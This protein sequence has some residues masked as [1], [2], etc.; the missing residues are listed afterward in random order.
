[1]EIVQSMQSPGV[2][3]TQQTCMSTLPY[4][5]VGWRHRTRGLAWFGRGDRNVASI[6]G[7]AAIL[8][9][10]RLVSMP[11]V[12]RSH[13]QVESLQL[14][15]EPS[16]LGFGATLTLPLHNTASNG[17]VG[18]KD[19]GESCTMYSVQKRGHL[20]SQLNAVFANVTRKCHSRHPHSPLSSNS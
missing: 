15:G 7:K 17:A 16:H 1:M 19:S 3:Q 4:R 9:I 10:M 20:P 18:N 2:L 13:G 5:Q 11:G 14:P 6:F 12:L 8:I